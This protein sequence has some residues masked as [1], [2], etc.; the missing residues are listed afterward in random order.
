MYHINKLNQV[1]F[2]K[3]LS[4]ARL[5]PKDLQTDYTRSTDSYL[6]T[7]TKYQKKAAFHILLFRNKPWIILKNETIA[8]AIGCS[9]KT[10][11]R[12]TNKFLKD[13]FITKN[14]Q[15][16]Y[17][18]NNYS[19]K[20]VKLSFSH[21]FQSL[22]LDNQT[23]YDSHGIRIDHNKKIIYSYRN[24]P[25]TKSSPVFS[26]L[27]SRNVVVS[28]RIAAG[29]KEH[30]QN[31]NNQ[32]KGMKVNSVQKQL[33]L[34]N[35]HDPRV[36]DMLHNPEIMAHIITP[37]IQKITTLLAL[38]EKEQF[39]LTAFTDET[40]EYV[41][42]QA[43]TAIES[44][45]VSY[46]SSRM[47][48]LI[49]FAAQH[50]KGNAI[51]PDWK[52]YYN[53]CEIVGIDT[54]TDRKPLI[55]QKARQQDTYKCKP[56]EWQVMQRLTVVEERVEKWKTEVKVLQQR[57]EEFTGPDPFY[58]KGL[59]IRSIEKAKQELM[60]AEEFQKKEE[61]NEKQSIL[62]QYSSDNMATCNA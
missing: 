12:A 44:K 11:T 55:I 48:W 52:W 16:K 2:Q 1:L 35:R 39:K 61:V 46:V 54:R 7:L 60:E 27:S 13:G 32:K 59:L 41:Y 30:T 19:I 36:K 58:L 20:N 17:A 10:V 51:K 28:S 47:E 5:A 40:L 38:D 22:S 8:L 33:I 62:Y 42:D 26:S 31:K 37:I 34:D 25:Q 3:N 6:S 29:R 23:L 50:C 24:V 57:L 4:V 45:K 43:K 9:T 18:P 21:W 56:G 14:Q 49:A 15:N 53:L